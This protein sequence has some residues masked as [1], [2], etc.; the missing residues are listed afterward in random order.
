MDKRNLMTF[1]ILIMS[2]NKADYGGGIYVDD[3]T[4]DS[5]ICEATIHD[6]IVKNCF[7]RN[8]SFC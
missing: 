4:A 3:D 1:F 2:H 7:I 5:D 6:S 8:E